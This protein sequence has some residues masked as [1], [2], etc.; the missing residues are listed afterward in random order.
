MNVALSTEQLSE[1]ADLVAERLAARLEAQPAASGMISAA[2]LASR[3][4]KSREFVYSNADSLGA[5]RLGAGLRPR[6]LFP[7]PLRATGEPHKA[8]EPVA[9]PKHLPGGSRGGDRV[10]LLPIRG[11][12]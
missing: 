12:S 2:E 6:L 9:R 7:W 10:S 8:P 4:G 3:L 1:L 11:R 5:V